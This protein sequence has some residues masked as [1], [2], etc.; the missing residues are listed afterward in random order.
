M[1]ENISLIKRSS[2]RQLTLTVHK[3]IVDIPS[4]GGKELFGN[5]FRAE[6]PAELLLDKVD[7]PALLTGELGLSLY[8]NINDTRMSFTIHMQHEMFSVS[9]LLV[10]LPFSIFTINDYLNHSHSLVRRLGTSCWHHYI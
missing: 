6:F 10:K 9:R 1:S 2:F 7:V 3:V 8:N 5:P 4:T